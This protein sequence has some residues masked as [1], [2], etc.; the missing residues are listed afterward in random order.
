MDEVLVQLQTCKKITDLDLK[1]RDQ[2]SDLDLWCDLD[3]YQ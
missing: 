3:Q 2:I 1:D